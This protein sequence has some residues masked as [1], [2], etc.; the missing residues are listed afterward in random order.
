MVNDIKTILAPK[1]VCPIA[2]TANS[3]GKTGEVAFL[4]LNRFNQLGF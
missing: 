1:A 3:A 4:G 2:F